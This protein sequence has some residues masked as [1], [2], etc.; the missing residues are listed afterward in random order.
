MLLLDRWHA[1]CSIRSPMRLP[2]FVRLC[3]VMPLV[4][5]CN[6]PIIDLAKE[7]DG[8]ESPCAARATTHIEIG[9]NLD[10]GRAISS[11]WDPG[12]PYGTSEFAIAGPTYTRDGD[13]IE[14][15]YYF[16][17]EQDLV[18]GWHAIPTC[19][20]TVLGG[21]RLTFANDGALIDT[22][23]TQVLRLPL[24]DGSLGEPITLSFDGVVSTNRFG[25]STYEQDGHAANQEAYCTE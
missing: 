19:D 16:A 15:T 21:G 1:N 20:T 9:T 10:R 22:Q 7:L 12:Q 24:R 6:L 14:L 18:W 5:A 4:S 23:Q 17:H 13:E 11:A 2:T 25:N 8:E 3:F